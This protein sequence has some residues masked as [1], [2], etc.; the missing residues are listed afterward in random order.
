[1]ALPSL[2]V[3]EGPYWLPQPASVGPWSP[4]ALHGGP[5]AALAVSVAEDLLPDPR[6]ITTRLT[7][8]LVRPVPTRPLD[9]EA[10]VLKSGRR[11]NL[12]EI[13]IL[14]AGVPVALALVQRTAVENVS[15]PDLVGTGVE[16]DPPTDGPDDFHP[17]GFS[18]APFAQLASDL[19]TARPEGILG[20]HPTDAW[21]HVFA[22][23][24]PGRPLSLAAAAAAA[25]D[26]GNAL[27]SPVTPVRGS[28]LFPNA[29]LTVHLARVP[30]CAW[31]RLA[32]QSTWLEHGIGHT[33]CALA[34]AAGMLGTVTVTLALADPGK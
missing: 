34:D 13:K 30:Q 3:R 4:Q 8:D 18:R 14:A 10:Q 24:L 26:Y 31:V 12:V 1:M 33:R 19:R 5:V 22:E 2:F 17:I 16:L 27:G 32:P 15:L 29:D 9:I 11:V 25:S 28:L 23:L 6:L 7:L 21:I 20:R